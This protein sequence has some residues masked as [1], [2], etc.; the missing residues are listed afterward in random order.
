MAATRALRM[1]GRPPP[2]GGKLRHAYDLADSAL[3]PRTADRPLD[4]D[5]VAAQEVL[6]AFAMMD[7]EI[8]TESR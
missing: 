4:D 7:I 2:G 8:T 5:L 6:D 1:Q 3:E